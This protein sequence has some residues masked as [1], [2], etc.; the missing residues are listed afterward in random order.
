MDLNAR[1]LKIMNLW[2]TATAYNRKVPC[3]RLCG[4]AKEFYAWCFKI[5]LYFRVQKKM[6]TRYLYLLLAPIHQ[7]LKSLVFTLLT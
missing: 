3:R 7:L 5:W 6:Q 2:P 1:I 4:E